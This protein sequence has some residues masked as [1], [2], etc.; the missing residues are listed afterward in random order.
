VDTSGVAVDRILRRAGDVPKAILE[1]AAV[2]RVNLIV[3]GSR[4]R[5][6]AASMFLGTMAEKLIWTTQTPM[7]VVKEKGEGASLLQLLFEEH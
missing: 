4:G 2:Q 6:A 5:R 7:L 3:L 1:D